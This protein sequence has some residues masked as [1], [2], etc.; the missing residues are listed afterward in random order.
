MEIYFATKQSGQIKNQSTYEGVCRKS[1]HLRNEAL[2]HDVEVAGETLR[3]DRF[4]SS[5]LRREILFPVLYIPL[6]LSPVK[7]L[8]PNS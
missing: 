8:S 2:V 1:S 7:Q 3:R 5:Q 4:D 6:T